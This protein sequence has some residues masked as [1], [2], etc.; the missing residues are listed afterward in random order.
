MEHNLAVNKR[1]HLDYKIIDTYE[2]G[3]VLRGGEVKSIKAGHISLAESYI[4]LK[5]EGGTPTLFLIKAHVPP[6]KYA[7]KKD[8]YDP[9]R[10]RQLLLTKKEIKRLIG[11]KQ[12]QGLT[13]IPLRIYT[14]H[15]FL[16]LEFAVA[17]GLK[18]ADKREVIKKRDVERQLRI[19]TKTRGRRLTP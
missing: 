5:Q 9:V 12:E 2:A 4:I 19:V 15:S 13:L 18:K 14:K 1:V 17:Q 6:Y 16:K 8:D 11:K 3:L 7:G 10:P